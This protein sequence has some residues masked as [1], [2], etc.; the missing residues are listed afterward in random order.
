MY[1]V[2]RDLPTVRAQWAQTLVERGVIS[3]D[4]AEHMV[5]DRMET[6]QEILESLDPT[7]DLG[8]SIPEP[9]SPGMARRVKTGVKLARLQAL[10]DALLAVPEGFNLHPKIARVMERRHASQADPD[11]Q[12]VDWATAEQLAL[13]T[14]LQDGIAVRMTGQD[15]ER[16]TFS[17]RHAVFHDQQTGETYTPLQSIPQ[18]KAAFEIHNSPLSE[19]AAIGF[20]YGYNIQEPER[21]VIWE[22]QYGD[23]VNNAQVMI[24]E[25]IS[26]ARAKWGQTPSLVLLLPH[27]YEGAG[28]DHSSGRLERFL[29]LTGETNMRIANP[30]TAAQFYHLLRRQAALLKTD[31]LPLII[32]TPKS[33][34]RQ[35]LAYSTL[36][37]LAEG[38]WQPVLDDAEARGRADEIRRLFLCSGK[39]WVDLLTSDQRD[40]NREVAITRVE[41]LYPFP[42][43]PLKDVIESYPN[44]EEITWVQEEPENMGAW[45]FAHP[46]VT[47]L[48]NG[49]W[50]LRYVGRASS[51]SPA[52]GSRAYHEANQATLIRQA[53]DRGP[54]PV[55]DDFIIS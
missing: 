2:I 14:I 40:A 19:N 18:A 27:G 38:H 48:A 43:E 29:Q 37:D 45:S 36:R 21:L 28:P 16:G 44:L 46:R 47:K 55:A 20:E 34:L 26:S 39:I 24:D 10:N 49:R 52:E 17:Q 7:V 8:E 50:P 33:L 5:R 42:A 11:A 4:G 22:A 15:V 9:P 41:Q 1:D 25:F 53:Y 32:M 31:P 6:L 51:A 30:S 3:A 12:A 13:A 35:T 23:F 54:D